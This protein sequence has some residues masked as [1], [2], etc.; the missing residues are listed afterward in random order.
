MQSTPSILLDHVL[1]FKNDPRTNILDI[2]FRHYSNK[3]YLRLSLILKHYELLENCYNN[4]AIKLGILYIEAY[5]QSSNTN[6]T[7][8]EYLA[9]LRKDKQL[10]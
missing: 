3:V 7:S 4:G 6:E 1:V 2:V 10:M 8:L 9:I 5:H